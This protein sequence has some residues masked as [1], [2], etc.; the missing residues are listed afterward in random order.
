MNTRDIAIMILKIDFAMSECY[1]D[2]CKYC[3]YKLRCDMANI[4]LSM[5]LGGEYN[6]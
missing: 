4:A 6:G 3:I 5:T 1:G 2:M